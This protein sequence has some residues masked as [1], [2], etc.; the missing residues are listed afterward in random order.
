MHA[1]LQTRRGLAAW[2]TRDILVLAVSSIALGVVTAA[3]FSLYVLVLAAMPL[4]AFAFAGVAYLQPFFVGYITRS[5]LKILVGQLIGGLAAIP[6]H[7]AGLVAVVGFVLYG[8]FAIVALFIGT[9]FRHF[10]PGSWALAGAVAAIFNLLWNGLVLQSFNFTLGVNL[11]IGVLAVASCLGFVFLA[12]A[13]V[14]AVARAGVLSGT[15][16][17]REQGQEI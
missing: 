9:R 5:P 4:A 15:E 2:T 14:L 6:F 17:G 11:L 8:V 7:P 3:V 1:P 13:L 12:R 10:G 16:L